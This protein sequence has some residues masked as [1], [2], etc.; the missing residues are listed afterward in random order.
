MLGGIKYSLLFLAIYYGKQ[1]E[2]RFI[3]GCNYALITKQHLW[4]KREIKPTLMES[5]LQQRRITIVSL[6]KLE[7]NKMQSV[8][9]MKM[10]NGSGLMEIRDVKKKI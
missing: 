9:W 5:E 3:I 8:L 4:I 1:I 2:S 6:V 7:L 10:Q